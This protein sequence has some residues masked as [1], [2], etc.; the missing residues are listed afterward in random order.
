[1]NPSHSAD[2]LVLG[3][4]LAG[5]SAA[6]A[7]LQNG[8]HCAIVDPAGPGSGASGAPMMLGNPAA[9]RRAKKTWRA[10]VCMHHLI[11][12]LHRIQTITG[13][14]CHEQ[15]GVLRP[16]LT[17]AI[18]K[19][20]ERSIEKYDWAEGWTEWIPRQEFERRY[21]FF[22]EHFGGL[23][24]KK[25]LTVRG[26]ELTNAFWNYLQKQGCFVKTGQSPQ[27]RRQDGRWS[28]FFDDGS[29]I[30][31]RQV[32]DATGNHQTVSGLWECIP[33]HP[34]KGQTATFHFDAPLTLHH[35]VSSL[36]YMAFMNDTPRKITVG[37]TYEHSF[38]HVQPDS[39]GLTYLTKKLE[40][41]LPGLAEQSVSAEQWASVRVTLPDRKPVI[42]RHPEKT[43]LWIIGAL[44]SKGLL[45]SRYLSELLVREMFTGEKIPGII[46]SE[47]F[48]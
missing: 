16:A 25:A 33:L 46:S 6:D 32:I 48:F 2:V 38:D 41:T 4:G 7:V 47:R 17:A 5:M 31:A 43:G 20:F 8:F 35:S 29:E 18:A 37:S 14:I 10:D 23:Q 22:A 30:T 9:G 1:V 13:I 12:L 11:S 3:A 39:E 27:L 40:R 36:G 42:G 26:G 45:M 28:V 34:V 19:D 15:N 44:G 24:V 21:P